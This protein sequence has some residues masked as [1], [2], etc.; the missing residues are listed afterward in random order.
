MGNTGIN[1]KADCSDNIIHEGSGPHVLTFAEVAMI[2]V[3]LSCP[4]TPAPVALVFVILPLS[5]YRA[6]RAAL[7]RLDAQ[8]SQR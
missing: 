4:C 5:Q 1:W 8:G 7:R 6:I 3:A 2:I